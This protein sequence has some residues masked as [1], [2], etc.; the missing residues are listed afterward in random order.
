MK[1]A[2]LEREYALGE[3][4]RLRELLAQGLGVLSVTYAFATLSAGRCGVTLSFKAAPELECQRCLQNF[5]MDLSGSNEI[6]FT[7]DAAASSVDSD[8]ELFT[9]RDSLVSLRE[10]AEEELLLALPIAPA[11]DT[12]LTCGKAPRYVRQRRWRDGR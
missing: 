9:M 5:R 3:L 12:P 6:E 8:R 11:C 2:V 10:L 4:P 7:D 1:R